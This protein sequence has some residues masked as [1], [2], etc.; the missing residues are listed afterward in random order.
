ML[1]T[2]VLR[3]KPEPGS[4][5]SHTQHSYSLVQESMPMRTAMA[6]ASS[7]GSSTASNDLLKQPPVLGLASRFVSSIVVG[8]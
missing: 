3:A 2:S 1:H 5:Y 7:A 6:V 8:E 4:S